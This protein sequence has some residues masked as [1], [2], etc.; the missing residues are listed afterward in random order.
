ME[1]LPLFILN[2]VNGTIICIIILYTGKKKNIQPTTTLLPLPKL[3]L[4]TILLLLVYSIR[5]LMMSI[6]GILTQLELAIYFILL[7]ALLPLL[8]LIL[9]NYIKHKEKNH[10]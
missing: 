4:L 7:L 6:A 10:L 2:I 5:L 1:H 9:P 3:Q 8:L